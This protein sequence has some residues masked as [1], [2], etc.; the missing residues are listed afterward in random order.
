VRS[1]LEL[2]HDREFLAQTVVVDGLE[3]KEVLAAWGRGR[4]ADAATWRGA[5]HDRRHDVASLTNGYE[6]SRAWNGRG[7][8]L[9]DVRLSVL[10]KGGRVAKVGA[11]WKLERAENP[12]VCL[13]KK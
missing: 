9:D 6:L 12:M 2:P 1:R 5:L 3:V 10:H 4:L 13:C 11:V 7:P 8:D